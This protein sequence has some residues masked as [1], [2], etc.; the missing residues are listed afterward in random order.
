MNP[1]P[2]NTIEKIL[3][4]ADALQ[5]KHP[6][7]AFAFAVIKKYGDE[8]AG[9]QAALLTYYGFLSL[10]PLLLVATSI[11]DI[12]AQHN[13]HLRARLLSD[14]TSYFPVV[15]NQLQ[16]NIHGSR[17]TGLALV[18]G[19]L[20]AIYGARGI[21]NAVRL[22]LDTSWGTPRSRRSSFWP[23]LLKSLTLLF[24]A[25][26]GLLLSTVLAGY[27]TAKLGH[28]FGFRLIPI[29]INIVILY[30]V[31]MY[32]FMYGPSER[33]KRDD[34]RVGA[35]A[36]V[37]G[38]LILQTIGGFLITHELRRT[39][40]A[41]GQ[42][43]LVLAIMFWIYLLAQVFTYSIEVNVVHLHHLWPRSLTGNKP[44][45]AD[46]QASHLRQEA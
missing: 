16:E 11:A 46:E 36:T 14:A 5:Q 40:S 31:C 26:L 18:V 22:V 7:L 32:V 19:L 6:A 15:G 20:V 33:R 41:Y 9:L 25:G 39:S 28:S 44:T 24:G 10:F 30:L 27:A 21:A 13:Q 29:A 12:I 35:I 4:T 23:G 42:F 3:A 37:I 45:A 38:L 34:V 2:K 1:H 17:G 8:Q 43:A